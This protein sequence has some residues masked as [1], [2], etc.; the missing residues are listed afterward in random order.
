MSAEE[1]LNRY[2]DIEKRAYTR[3]INGEMKLVKPTDPMLIKSH[4]KSR[5]ELLENLK[6]EIIG[7]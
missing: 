5:I 6:E 7:E 2:I 4:I 1:V 3:L